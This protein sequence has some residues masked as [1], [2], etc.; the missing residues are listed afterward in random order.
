MDI[1]NLSVTS[2]PDTFP[3]SLEIRGY[4]VSSE[5]DGEVKPLEASIEMTS[6][7]DVILLEDNSMTSEAD[8]DVILLEDDSMTSKADGNVTPL[9]ASIV[10]SEAN[11]DVNTPL[12]AS[13]VTSEANDGDVTPLEASS[14]TSEANDDVTPLEA[15]SVTSEVNDDDVTPLEASSVTSEA[16]DD[17]VTLLEASSVTSEADLQLLGVS[18]K[19]QADIED[20]V[21]NLLEL[22]ERDNR[23]K[24][25][26]K[27]IAAQL[28]KRRSLK[29]QL[30]ACESSLQQ[31]YSVDPGGMKKRKISSLLNDQ[32]KLKSDLQALE[33]EALGG[34][35]EL[36]RCNY[37]FSTDPAFASLIGGFWPNRKSRSAAGGVVEDQPSTETD[38]EKSIRLGEVTAF[39]NSLATTSEQSSSNAFQSYLRHQIQELDEA[40]KRGK[41]ASSSCSSK[42]R[43]KEAV[44]DK[45]S[46]A[47]KRKKKEVLR[48]DSDEDAW[49]TD[50]SDWEG[51]D[52]E[53][54]GVRRHR[55]HF[56]DG[57]K[58][59]Y[60]ERMKEWRATS[61]QG[62]MSLFIGTTVAD[63]DP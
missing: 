61:Q 44:E 25:L 63:P 36:E 40:E 26:K 59:S 37:D 33:G 28:N 20:S 35:E 39:G 9:E 32:E 54:D 21:F 6:D 42:K 3:A 4:S 48:A 2:E 14:V 50:D 52:D 16:N 8:D 30:D 49:H 55:R 34:L 58:D 24:Q 10:M 18:A 27:N 15:S 31:L 57:D 13:S 29:K 60:L 1:K 43:R 11:G 7:D 19:S 46:A 47:S 23:V 45:S 53:E 22:R 56:D 17:D 62:R 12:E 5:A 38:Q 51:T 41:S